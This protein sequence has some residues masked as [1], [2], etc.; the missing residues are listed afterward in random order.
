MKTIKFYEIKINLIS[1]YEGYIMK[2]YEDFQSKCIKVSFLNEAIIEIL[3]LK[4][5]KD[6]KLFPYENQVQKITIY[7]NSY[8]HIYKYRKTLTSLKDKNCNLII[9]YS[10]L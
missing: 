7:F 10:Y 8:K 9:I 6:Q 3:I 4:V 1:I 5:L 2:I